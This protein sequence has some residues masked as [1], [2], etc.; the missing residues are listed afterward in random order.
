MLRFVP[1]G[2]R[3]GAQL[4]QGWERWD[5]SPQPGHTGGRQGVRGWWGG[6]KL[7]EL[8]ESWDMGY[9]LVPAPG[10]ANSHGAWG[11][12]EGSP[13]SSQE[14]GLGGRVALTWHL[15]WVQGSQLGLCGETEA[16]KDQT[17]R[18]PCHNLWAALSR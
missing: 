2:C 10:S 4:A 17:S 18:E 15:I 7:T 12:G 9:E 3:D 6:R 11:R 13:M 1:A 5:P 16:Q 14:T 8:M